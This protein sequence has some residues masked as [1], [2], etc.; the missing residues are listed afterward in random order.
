MKTTYFLFPHGGEQEEL[1]TSLSAR[2]NAIP[3]DVFGGSV[4]QT[5]MILTFRPALAVTD[6]PTGWRCVTEYVD[7]DLI[8]REVMATRFL[9]PARLIYRTEE[10][11]NWSFL[12]VEWKEPEPWPE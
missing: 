7:P 5:P 11:G 4:E 10:D 8:V 1:L 6:W 9:H 12:T 3:R 2:V